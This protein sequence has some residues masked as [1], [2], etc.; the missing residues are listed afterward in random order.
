MC[1]RVG[2]GNGWTRAGEAQTVHTEFFYEVHVG[3]FCHLEGV[4]FLDLLHCCLMVTSLVFRKLS[5]G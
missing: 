1:R 5:S 3:S 2:C 4:S